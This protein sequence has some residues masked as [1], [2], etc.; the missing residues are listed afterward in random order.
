M[1]NEEDI[2]LIT[3]YLENFLRVH[4]TLM[5]IINDTLRLCNVFSVDKVNMHHTHLYN[6]NFPMSSFK[7]IM[8]MANSSYLY[9][10]DIMGAF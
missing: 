7:T 3:Q 9:S 8:K 1:S 10:Q 5:G 2:K 4:N 6:N